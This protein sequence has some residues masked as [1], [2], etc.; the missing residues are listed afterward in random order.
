[1]EELLDMELRDDRDEEGV[2]T[3]FAGEEGIDG[4]TVWKELVKRGVWAAAASR[5]AAC[6][7][8]MVDGR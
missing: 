3:R 2:R 8:E 5:T 7:G 4:V 1:M 6:D